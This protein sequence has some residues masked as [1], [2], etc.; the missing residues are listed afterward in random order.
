MTKPEILFVCRKQFGYSIDN[1]Y[2]CKYL[3]EYF[4]ITFISP[5][6]GWEKELLEEVLTEYVVFKKNKIINN[7]RFYYRVIDLIKKRPFELIYL[8]RSF[9]FFFFKIFNPSKIFIYDIRSGIISNSYLKRIFRIFLIKLDL[10]IYKNITIISDNLAKQLNIKKYHLL[11][12]GA[13]KFNLPVRKFDEIKLVY[14]GSFNS[15]NIEETIE[16]FSLFV[17]DLS[18]FSN[19]SYDIY[20][21]GNAET[22]K[23]IND[24]ILV[25]NLSKSVFLHEK[26]LHKDLPF[27]L[28][29]YNVGVSYVPITPFFNVQPPTKT[30]EYLFAGMPVIATN[31]AENGKIITEENGVLILDNPVSFKNGLITIS[32]RIAES[33]FDSEKIIRSC[34]P[35]SWENIVVNN[36]KQ[37]IESLLE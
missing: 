19:I 16:G 14:V 27:I 1:Y 28:K 21:F 36:F 34:L 5:D 22:L 18:F 12:L 9:L 4:R 17:K 25:N 3:R 23:R 15:R 24:A 26:I 37:Y 32:R 2:H 8:N 20:G 11:P 13:E 6:V 29:K 31:T 35:H 33:H 30:F 10:L 7:L